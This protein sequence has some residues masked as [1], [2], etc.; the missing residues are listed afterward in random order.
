MKTAVF[1]TSFD[2]SYLQMAN[3]SQN[4]ELVFFEVPLTRKTIA[5][6][7]GFPAVCIKPP[8]QLDARALDALAK[9]GTRLIALRSAGFDYVDI[10]AAQ[11]LGVTVVRVPAYSPYAIAEY[12]VG[13]ILTLNR[14]IHRAYARV[15][16]GNFAIDGL[17]GFDL[18]AR[19]VGIIGTGH[20]GTVV[21]R[22]M[23]GFGCHLL[24]YSHTAQPECESLGVSYVPLAELLATSDIITLH[25]PL[26]SETHHLIDTQALSQMKDG[27]MLINTGR[28]G[29][30][31]SK[32]VIRAL[33]SGR[34]GY[35]GLDVYE[36]E[37]SLFF[38]DLSNTVIRDDVFERL[39]T[40]PNVIVTSHQAWLTED[41]IRNIADT[42]LANITAFEQ[43]QACP[44]EITSVH[45]A[46]DGREVDTEHS[47]LSPL[48]A[49]PHGD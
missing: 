13:L 45:R 19:T 7:G 12:T 1:D 14:K 33:K 39:L 27:V 30:I 44:N 29:L 49:G 20:I 48:G 31:D 35:L 37:A 22:I 38:K 28:G 15:R 18:H 17:V 3:A 40:F 46:A 10:V 23:K 25:C 24:A 42:T 32:A 11:K 41:A 9:H 47:E 5:L 21:A 16:E 6:A 26:T 8:S 36:K 43:G 4:H 34:I 2:R